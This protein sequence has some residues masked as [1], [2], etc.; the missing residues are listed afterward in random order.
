MNLITFTN[1]KLGGRIGQINMPAIISCRANA[2][3]AK[4]CYAT[5]GNFTYDKVRKSHMEKYTLAIEHPEDFFRTLNMELT[6]SNV[7]YI[8][9]HSSGDIPTYEYFV[10]MCRLARKHKDVKF[11]CFTKKYEIINKYLSEKHI[12]PKNLTVVLS[13]WGYWLPGNPYGLPMAYVHF[14]LDE[15][16]RNI[17]E[18]ANICGGN[19]GECIYGSNANCWNMKKGEAVKFHIHGAKAKSEIARMKEYVTI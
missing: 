13:S 17:P 19:C 18:S 16:D 15:V 9:W 12:I 14:G 5:A 6:L 3:C 1:S 2:P 7:K 4:G 8:R 10:G 11:L